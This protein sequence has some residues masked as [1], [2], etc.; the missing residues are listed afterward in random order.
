M[1]WITSLYGLGFPWDSEQA[2]VVCRFCVVL[3]FYRHFSLSLLSDN[4]HFSLVRIRGEWGCVHHHFY[5]SLDIIYLFISSISCTA[6]PFPHV[7]PFHFIL[8]LNLYSCSIL[9]R[10]NRHVCNIRLDRLHF[11]KRMRSRNLIA[12]LPLAPSPSRFFL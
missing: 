3:T 2:W 7:L 1:V 8:F 6:S 4:S 9:P 5:L 12:G 10:Q 11:S